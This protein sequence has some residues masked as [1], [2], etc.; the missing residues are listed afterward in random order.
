[1]SQDKTLAIINA[2][3]NDYID[4]LVANKGYD[5]EDAIRV[6]DIMDYERQPSKRNGLLT[7]NRLIAECEDA[8]SGISIEFVE[9]YDGCPACIS[10]AISEFSEDRAYS[11]GSSIHEFIADNIGYVNDTI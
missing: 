3:H 9:G 5:R 1:M 11:Y 6:A 7:I 10:D 4:W 8:M 2:E